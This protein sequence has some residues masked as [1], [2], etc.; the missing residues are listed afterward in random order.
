MNR[1][2]N[3]EQCEVRGDDLGDTTKKKRKSVLLTKIDI[4]PSPQRLK[5]LS[6][7]DIV[8]ELSPL[9][10]KSKKPRDIS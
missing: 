1:D 6:L 9:S 4:T 10:V 8:T 7:T 2:E 5:R 3:Q